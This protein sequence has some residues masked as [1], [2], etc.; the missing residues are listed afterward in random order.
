M[1]ST[2]IRQIEYDTGTATLYVTF[3]SGTAYA[4]FMV[5][6]AVYDDFRAAFSKGRFFGRRIRP[7]Y[8]SRRL[9]RPP[10]GSIP[11][12]P[13]ERPSGLGSGPGGLLSAAAHP[14]R[15]TEPTDAVSNVV[16]LLL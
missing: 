8:R 3:T 7:V 2:V 13:P 1:P 15:P 12:V 6:R 10:E 16:T 9:P 4:Y 14:E 11:A 5:P